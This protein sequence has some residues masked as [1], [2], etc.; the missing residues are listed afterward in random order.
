VNDLT[1]GLL[2]AL[3][4]T[5]QP[6][7]VSNLIQQHTG[8]TVAMT[9]ASDPV[10]QELQGLM[11]DDDKAVDEVDSWIQTNAVL[12]AA[13][14]GE[15]K[16]AL[17]KRIHVRLDTM[18]TRYD[19]FLR[20]HPD[21]SR[22]YLAYGTFLNDIGEEELAHVQFEN[23]ARIDPKN[24]AAWNNLANYYGENG[25]LTNAFVDYARAIELDP[26]EPVYYRNF[27]T[28]VYLFRKDAKE[29]YRINEQQVFDKA[30]DLY[31]KA[32]E[33]A[34]DDFELATDYAQSYYG[35]R[36]LRT[37]DALLAWTNALKIAHN[38]IEREGVYV[39]LAR[40]NVGAMRF[41]EARGQLTLVTN[42]FYTDLKNR[43]A[44]NLI[45]REKAATNP[46]VVVPTNQFPEISTNVTV[47]TTNNFPAIKAQ[48]PLT[49]VIR[50][51]PNPPVFSP[52]MAGAMTNVPPNP[53]KPPELQMTPP[54]LHPQPAPAS[55]ED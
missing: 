35:I 30:L 54:P 34:P 27:A 15:S 7:A 24:P 26:A 1:I 17:A 50:P 48:P 25:P 31:R 21:S 5:N 45:E 49:N 55:D 22:G 23:A 39:H 14:G 3:L 9:N 40:V 10:E 53:P 16:E 18:R 37:N 13:G 36:P 46:V 41:D 43:L 38:D 42:P 11:A 12:V 28:T 33:F 20:R 8:M 44:R 29:F 2:G 52:K 32:M 51:L 6:L 4:A 47:T 19:E